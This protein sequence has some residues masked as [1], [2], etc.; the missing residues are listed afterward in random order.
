MP[1]YNLILGKYTRNIYIFY[2]HIFHTETTRLKY[3]IHIVSFKISQTRKA[4]SALIGRRGRL[5]VYEPSSP[6]NSW[7]DW[8]QSLSGNSTWWAL[9]GKNS[10]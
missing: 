4:V 2:V 6:R 1:L 7:S 5:N 3:F 10:Y 9:R 8:R